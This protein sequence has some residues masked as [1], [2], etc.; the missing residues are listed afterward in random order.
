MNLKNF[1]TTYLFGLRPKQAL[2]LEWKSAKKFFWDHGNPP[3]NCHVL[4]YWRNIKCT[5]FEKNCSK[6]G[7]SKFQPN[8]TWPDLTIPYPNPA[9][10]PGGYPNPSGGNQRLS[11]YSFR[12]TRIRNCH[13]SPKILLKNPPNKLDVWAASPLRSLDIDDQICWV[14]NEKLE[15][16]DIDEADL[17]MMI[18]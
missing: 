18:I 5:Y 12:N 17:M 11:K 1:N 3:S 6:T 16:F 10:G 14:V 8:L 2:K 13:L 9:G 7:I 15:V 4:L